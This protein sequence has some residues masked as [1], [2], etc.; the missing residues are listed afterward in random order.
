MVNP[1]PEHQRQEPHRRGINIARLISS[2]FATPEMFVIPILREA[3]TVVTIDG[4]VW[5]GDKEFIPL[6][7]LVDRE[8]AVVGKTR[9]WKLTYPE[10]SK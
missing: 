5:Q 2:Q 8:L 10:S 9:Q 1:E 7:Q 6:S 4:A 3:D